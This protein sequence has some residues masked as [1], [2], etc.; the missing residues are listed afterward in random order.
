MLRIVEDALDRPGLDD[1]AGVH[2]GDLVGDLRDDAEVVG[3]QQHRGAG[4]SLQFAHQL[5]DLRLDGHVERRR[6]LVGDEQLGIVGKRH[7]DH[8]ALPHA[9]GE[10]VRIVVETPFGRRDPHPAEHFQSA[11]AGLLPADPAMAAPRPRPPG[12]RP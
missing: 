10:L 3:D 11:R 4:V 8:H 5:E 1:P 6:R 9:A 2:D 12:R 7:G